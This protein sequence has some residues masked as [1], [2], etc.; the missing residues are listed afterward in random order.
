MDDVHQPFGKRALRQP[1]DLPGA[2][3]ENRKPSLDRHRDRRQR[4]RP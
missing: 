2:V 1:G 3:D 4:Q